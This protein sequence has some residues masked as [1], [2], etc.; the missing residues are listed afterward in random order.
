VGRSIGFWI[1]HVI[2]DSETSMNA[3]RSIWA[4]PKVLGSFRWTST[5][6]AVDV[7]SEFL[8]LRA[9][10]Q[11]TRTAMRLP[12]LGF[13]RSSCGQL[14]RSFAVRGFGTM[15]LSTASIETSGEAGIDAL[16][17]DGD[18]RIVWLRDL[19]ITVGAPQNDAPL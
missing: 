19:R 3:G 11:P 14:A 12:I 18:R 6:A 10:T 17:F 8:E 15:S 7:A 4:L 13:A 1:S 16:G 5:L 9:R 2:V